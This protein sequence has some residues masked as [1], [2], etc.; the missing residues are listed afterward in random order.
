MKTDFN[1]I[2]TRDDYKRMTE[3]LKSITEEFASTSSLMKKKNFRIY[4]V[5]YIAILEKL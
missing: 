5:R 4:K 3:N 1:Q 2:L